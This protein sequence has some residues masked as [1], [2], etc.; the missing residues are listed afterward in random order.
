LTFGA[1][2]IINDAEEEGLGDVRKQTATPSSRNS[3]DLD[4]TE[5]TELAGGVYASPVSFPFEPGEHG[6]IAMKV[7]DFWENKEA[8]SYGP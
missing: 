3:S 2:F 7:I 4:A 5:R 6:R 1:E 8:A